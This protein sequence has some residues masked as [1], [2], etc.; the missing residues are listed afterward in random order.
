MRRERILL[1]LARSNTHCASSCQQSI[2]LCLG[3][4]W[5][6]CYPDRPGSLRAVT[7]MQSRA[8]RSAR[9]TASVS[10]KSN[11]DQWLGPSN[12]TTFVRCLRLLD[13]DQLPDWPG[14]T[15]NVFTSKT[16]QQNLQARIKAVEW[17]LY[18]LFEIYDPKETQTV[19]R[20]KLLSATRCCLLK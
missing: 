1:L 16:V 4:W 5:R 9:T 13:L 11:S 14:I 19:G 17:S 3:S 20:Q 6:E 8:V 2:I 7:R 12:I 15:D 18:R 10:Q